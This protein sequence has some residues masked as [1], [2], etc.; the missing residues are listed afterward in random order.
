MGREAFPP[1]KGVQ[2]SQEERRVSQGANFRATWLRVKLKIY[3]QVFV[4]SYW[5]VADSAGV[6]DIGYC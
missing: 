6:G 1:R 2:L 4:R 5:L 3:L